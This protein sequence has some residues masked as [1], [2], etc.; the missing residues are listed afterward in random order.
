MRSCPCIMLSS[1]PC[2]L[3]MRVSIFH[4][5]AAGDWVNCGMCGE[6]AHFGCDRRPGLGAFKVRHQISLVSW[7]WNWIFSWFTTFANNQQFF[8]FD[9]VGLCKNRRTRIHLSAMQ[10]FKFQ[11]E[12]AE[13][14]ERIFLNDCCFY[15]LY[16]SPL[17]LRWRN[18]SICSRSRELYVYYLSSPHISPSKGGLGHG[19]TPIPSE[20]EKWRKGSQQYAETLI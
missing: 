12:T 17:H 4:S 14:N 18:M 1:D 10:H 7:L 3:T 15:I 5:S 19:D 9:I 13:N 2:L 8:Y 11:E 6:W 16:I 20:R